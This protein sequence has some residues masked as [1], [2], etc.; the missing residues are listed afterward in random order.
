MVQDKPGSPLN[1]AFVVTRHIPVRM[2]DGGALTAAAARLRAHPGVASASVGEAGRLA[3]RYDASRIGF[4]E[5]ERILDE[6]GVARPAGFAWRIKADWFR[7]TDRNARA[8]A[9]ATHACC[10]RPPAPP[11]GGRK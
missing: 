6:A 4:E 7:F 5:I 2:A 1:E 11:G 10:S 3:L 8:N 9:H